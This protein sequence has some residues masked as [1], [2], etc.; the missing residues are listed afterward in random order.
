MKRNVFAA[1]HRY[2]NAALSI[3]RIRFTHRFLGD[4]QHPA[5]RRKLKSGSQAGYTRSDDKKIRLRNGVHLSGYQEGLA[6]QAIRAPR[7][8]LVCVGQNCACGAKRGIHD[9]HGALR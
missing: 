3:V 1:F 5:M 8:A 6:V 2:G 7:N 4:N 9:E